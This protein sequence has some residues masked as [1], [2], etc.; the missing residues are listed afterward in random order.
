MTVKISSLAFVA[1]TAF[2]GPAMAGVAAVPAPEV[3]AGV[4][5]LMLAAGVVYFIHRRRSQP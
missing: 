1:L 4:F 2:A 5:G 3:G